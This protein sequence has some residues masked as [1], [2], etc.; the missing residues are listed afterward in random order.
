M[1]LFLSFLRSGLSIH[2]ELGST[3]PGL[4][5][6]SSLLRNVGSTRLRTRVHYSS[7]NLFFFREVGPTRLV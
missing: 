7:L 1:S 3:R 6:I 2:G 4:L 5:S